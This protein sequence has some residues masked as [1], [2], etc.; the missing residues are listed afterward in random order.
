VASAPLVPLVRPLA[1]LGRDDRLLAGGKAA[2]LGE[3]LRAG[4]QV[5]AGCVVTTIAFEDTMRAIDPE[6]S[7][8]RAISALDADDHAA[9][10]RVT[11]GI[12]ER[13]AAAPLSGELGAAISAG[14]RELGTGA[15]V[16][17]RSSA[18]GED[19]ADAS[20]AGLQDT[21]LW[22]RGG[23][24]VVDRVRGCWASLYNV[25]SV[26]YRLRRGLEEG[27]MAM[28]VVIQ[29]MV[30][31]RCSGVA[32]TRSP[33][34]GDRSVISIEAS[35]GLGSA[36]V[37]GEVTPD[38]WVVSKV[39]GEILRRRVSSKLRQHRPD[40][41]GRGV[42]DEEVPSHL[43]DQPCLSDE[44]VQALARVARRVERHY[45]SSQDIEWAV[46]RDVAL[47]G[48]LLLLQSRPETVWS[49]REAGPV[50]APLA[51][52]FDHVVTLLGSQ[53]TTREPGG[54]GAAAGGGPA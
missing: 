53:P 37:S 4:V 5:P 54:G 45:G 46:A 51:R 52:A 22:V 25:E 39:T 38:T 33:T 2:S 30:D 9:V 27:T 16:A 49:N 36:V 18:T 47:P 26:T 48:G 32:F 15:P 20:F 10:S 42:V 17:V 13:V 21:F 23:D 34:S 41:S 11:G 31:A 19:A 14:Y 8:A 35:W 40:P 7:I 28:G 3:L 44:E 6:R 43:R 50:A 24:E 12:R 29:R 1:G